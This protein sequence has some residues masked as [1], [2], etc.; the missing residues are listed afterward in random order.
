MARALPEDGRAAYIQPFQDSLTTPEGQ[1]PIEE[2]AD[3]RKEVLASVL[4]EVKGLGDGSEKGMSS[5]AVRSPNVPHF[6]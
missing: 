5:V 4:A 6:R 1:K 3:R 2:D